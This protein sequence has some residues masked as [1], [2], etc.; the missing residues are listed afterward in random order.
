MAYLVRGFGGAGVGGPSSLHVGPSAPASPQ[1][2]WLWVDTSDSDYPELKAWSGGSWDSVDDHEVHAGATLPANAWRGAT[3]LLLEAD[4]GSVPGWYACYETGT[5]T[6][7]GPQ[8]QASQQQLAARHPRLVTL[9]SAAAARPADPFAAVAAGAYGD[10]GWIARPSGWE[11][12]PADAVPG[13][14]ESRWQAEA[15]ATYDEAA[16]PPRWRFGPGLVSPATA[17]WAQYSTHSDGRGAHAAPAAADRWHRRRDPDTGA[18]SAWLPLYRY[19]DVG[20]VTL[21]DYTTL[22]GAGGHGWRFSHQLPAPIR[23]AAY[24][25]L[26]VAVHVDTPGH[27]A[28]DASAIVLPQRMGVALHGDVSDAYREGITQVADFDANGTRRLSSA[29][30]SMPA[31]DVNLSSGRRWGVRWQFRRGAGDPA[32]TASYLDV[33]R[34]RVTGLSG[35]RYRIMIR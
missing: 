11:L 26:A 22:V 12:A 6:L 21:V 24:H 27:P 25:E 15:L 4:G 33:L 19:R 9:W 20:W 7:I 14:G 32:G 5:W 17:Y 13:V 30:V 2:G 35:G 18:W 8:P 29:S 23:P 16:S 28:W 10:D 34:S 1:D 3:W 31:E